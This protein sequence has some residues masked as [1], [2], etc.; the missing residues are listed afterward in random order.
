MSPQR[1]WLLS[2]PKT[3][4]VNGQESPG[5][6]VGRARCADAFGERELQAVVGAPVRKAVTCGAPCTHH[7]HRDNNVIVNSRI[8]SGSRQLD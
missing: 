3:L 6:T 2:A 5:H 4:I 8:A 7:T 1:Y